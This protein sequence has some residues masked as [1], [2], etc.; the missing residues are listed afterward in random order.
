MS[1]C[2]REIEVEDR[3]RKRERDENCMKVR[4]ERKK[5]Y[6]LRRKNIEK[7]CRVDYYSRVKRNRH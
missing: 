3:A 7:D 1:K 6:M 4:T 5:K 2:V